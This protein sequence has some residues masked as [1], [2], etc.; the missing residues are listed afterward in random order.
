MPP[1]GV[2][3]LMVTFAANSENLVLKC[4][5]LGNIPP[6]STLGVLQ[7]D[8]DKAQK[9]LSIWVPLCKMAALTL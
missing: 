2:S 1:P 4:V 7:F 9:A 3:T 6:K 5:G 8:V